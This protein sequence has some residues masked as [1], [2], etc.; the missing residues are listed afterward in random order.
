VKF[1]YGNKAIN[2]FLR[3]NVTLPTMPFSCK[4]FVETHGFTIYHGAFHELF[5][6]TMESRLSRSLFANFPF[7]RWIE[8]ITEYF[9]EF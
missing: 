6:L 3:K 5:F 9:H 8:A 4:N 2:P 1:L 7:S